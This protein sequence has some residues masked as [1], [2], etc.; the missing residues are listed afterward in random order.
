MPI[1]CSVKRQD[2][3]LG[4]NDTFRGVWGM[5]SPRSRLVSKR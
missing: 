2:V 3:R 5:R 1:T 4:G